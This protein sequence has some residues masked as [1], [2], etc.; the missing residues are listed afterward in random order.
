MAK[1]KTTAPG[2]SQTQPQEQ[3]SDPTESEVRALL[4]RVSMCRTRLIG[5]V[6]F[7][8]HL[9]LNLIPRAATASDKVPTAGVCQDGTLILNHKYCAT[10][11][12]SQLAGLLCHEVLHPALFCFDRQ[13][14]R[15]AMVEGPDGNVFS[16]WNLAHDLSFNPEIVEL[17]NNTSHGNGSG[18]KVIELPPNA[19]LDQS[20]AKKAAEEIY[21]A[22]LE[23][24]K[25]NP[26]SG[27]FGIS[28][29][30]GSGYGIGDD[31]R[32]DLSSTKDGQKAAHGDKTAQNKLSSDWKV[33][34]V[35]A[36]QEHARANQGVLPSNLRKAVE[37]LTNP[38]V[39]WK[40]V[41]SRWI[42][43]NGR[44]CDYTYQRPARRSESVGEF[45]PSLKK[46]GVDNI[47]VL[48]D[49]S[50]SMNGRETEILSEVQGICEDLGIGVRVIVC[51]AEVHADVEDL[52]DA[53]DMIAHV[54][55][56]GGSSFCPA[57]TRLEETNY[58]GVIVAFTDGYIDVPASKPPLVKDVLWVIS[59]NSD[60]DPTHGKWGE[61]LKMND[62][63]M[64]S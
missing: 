36:A 29:Y 19:A 43:E 11:T 38:K 25:R 1:K 3:F 17:A 63:E 6:P 50:G 49:T 47:A 51:D 53:L 58:E 27:R 59:E 14:P 15:R 62:K 28:Q 24:A 30:P 35:A 44:R 39:P 20:Y 55:G 12:D 40:D 26:Q 64:K 23:K 13:G 41:L 18:N 4:E 60:Q 2:P 57:F 10:L 5:H 56:G 8:G 45:L 21:D 9:A 54:R 32:D 16:L 34:V 31:M 7:F 52:T 48:W 37:E 33:A 42:G 46:N 22:I 61:V